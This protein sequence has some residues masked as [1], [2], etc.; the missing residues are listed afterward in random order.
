MR[1][2]EFR[3]LKK[4]MIELYE[5]GSKLSESLNITEEINKR[6]NKILEEYSI[7]LKQLLN[8]DLSNIPFEEWEGL[9]LIGDDFDFSKTHAN[10]DFSLFENIY[11]DSINLKGCNVKGLSYLGSYSEDSFDPE[12]ITNH[13]EYFP[14]KDLPSEIREKF[15]EGKLQLSDLLD[16][17]SLKKCVH[18]HSFGSFVTSSASLVSAIGLENTLKMLDEYPEFIKT[19]TYQDNEN[20]KTQ[21]LLF[22]NIKQEDIKTYED[23]KIAVYKEVINGLKNNYLLD[24]PPLEI[25]PEEM[26]KLYENV[27]IK[28]GELPK[29]IENDYYNGTLSLR[30]IRIYQDILKKKDIDIGIRQSSSSIKVEEAFGS[31]WNYLEIIPVQFDFIISDYVS[32]LY[33]EDLKPIKTEEDIKELLTDSVK[34]ELSR[35]FSN[36]RLDDLYLYSKYVSLEEVIDDVELLKFIQKFGIE[37]IVEYNKKNDYI[38]QD[39]SGSRIRESLLDV[40]I[41]YNH[42]DI[43]EPDLHT[44]IGKIINIMRTRENYKTLSVLINYG[45]ELHKLFPNEV[46]DYNKLGELLVDSDSK[47]T[48]IYDLTKGVNGNIELLASLINKHPYLVQAIKNIDLIIQGREDTYQRL[49]EILDN[50]RFIELC[51]KYGEV[52]PILFMYLTPEEYEKLLESIKIDNNYELHLNK[53]IYE[54]LSKTS[55]INKLLLPP[56]FVEMYPELFLKSD[57]PPDLI[58]AFYQGKIPIDFKDIKQNPRWIP[59]LLHVD[60]KRCFLDKKVYYNAGG[61]EFAS[62]P[63]S[64]YDVIGKFLS[65][66]EFLN[67]MV[68]YGQILRIADFDFDLEDDKELCYRRIR[69]GVYRALLERR[70]TYD[71]KS[72]PKDF[73][74]RYPELFLSEEAAQKYPALYSFFY[75]KKL[76]PGMIQNNPEWIKYLLDKNLLTTCDNIIF[77]FVNDFLNQGLDNEKLL[78]VFSKYGNYLFLGVPNFDGL[79]DVNNVEEYIENEIV[80]SINLRSVGYNHDAK[81]LFGKEHPELFLDDIAPEELKQVFYNFTANSPLTFELLK[82]HPE[83]MPFLKDKNVLLS[84]QKAN[85]GAIGLEILFDTYGV[86]EAIRIGLK[87]PEHVTRI[88]EMERADLLCHWYDKYHFVPN[89]MVMLYFP[90]DN[91]D[92]FVSSGKKWT[93]LMKIKRYSDTDES[94][95]ALLKASMCFGVFDSDMDGFNKTIQLFTD[96]PKTLNEVEMEKV[97]K[98]IEHKIGLAEFLIDGSEEQIKELNNQLNLLNSVYEKKENGTYSLKINQQKNKDSVTELRKIMEQA[99]VSIIL[100]PDKAHKL[101]GRFIMKYEPDFRDFILDNMD[102]I[103]SSDEYIA[104]IS[105]MQKKWAEIKALNSNRVLTLDLALAY[106]KSNN[107]ENVEMGNDRL[108]EVSNNAGYSQRDFDTLQQIYN[109]GKLRTFN[110]IPRIQNT[111]EDYA[112]EILRLDDP[113]ALAIGTLTDCCQEIGNDAETSMEHSMVDKHGVVFVIKDKE[114]NIVAQSWMWRNKNVICFDNIEIPSRAFTR[115]EKSG[116][117]KVEF[118]DKVFDIYKQAANELMKKDG[119]TYKRLLDEGKITKEQYESL[120]LGKVTVGMGYNDIADSLKRNATIDKSEI[121]RPLPFEEPVELTHGLYTNDSTSQHVI[122]GDEFVPES[123][124]ETL[125]LYNDDYII[126]DD[127]NIKQENVMMLQKL[128]YSMDDYNYSGSLLSTNSKNIMDDIAYNYD[129]NPTNTKIIMNANFAIIYDAT[130]DQIVIGDV[131]YNKTVNLSGR[132]TDISNVIA[133]QIRMAIEQI[134][135]GGKNIDISRLDKEKLEMCSKAMNLTQEEIDKERGISHGSR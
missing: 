70:I 127:T 20:K 4:R 110:S 67:I 69:N 85:L 1:I 78:E 59:H 14:S 40:I 61:Y 68:E 7:T 72:V 13:P 86:D 132:E 11:Y 77:K 91:S 31:V 65:Q 44:Y 28:T 39:M 82:Q 42:L 104:Y 121:S 117:S 18:S 17:S 116:I 19:I 29:E 33:G 21:N 62:Q 122:A 87:N 32:K 60:L 64:I 50:K 111:T 66:E 133:L 125:T 23:A 34:Y 63:A 8:S 57:A 41:G 2:D 71:E 100:T 15:Y 53:K 118:T 103:L 75:A 92:K 26:L 27:Y 45:G 5:E 101:F 130:S 55:T 126:Y 93:Q 48:I 25:M 84:L 106:V 16:Y 97:V 83:W 99:N 88:L 131:L 74:E 36:E 10:I 124:E 56:S 38:L 90:I 37:Q 46:I 47:E 80:K 30:E 22:R 94:L 119:E 120:K 73:I 79:V 89:H 95:S 54:L 108:A 81:I 51:S 128:E 135:A 24:Y 123:N 115:A 35:S 129:L 113:L 3:N 102:I 9:S 112:Y 49:K 12:F 109:Y 96:I 98:H 58:K 52:L 6:I 76:T 114:N 43:D 134:S 105:S 107:Y